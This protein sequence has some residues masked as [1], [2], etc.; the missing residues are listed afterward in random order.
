MLSVRSHER[1]DVRTKGLGSWHP[2]TRETTRVPGAVVRMHD[3]V[4]VNLEV[5][6][7]PELLSPQERPAVE[8]WG[9]SWYE[10]LGGGCGQVVA[11]LE[12]VP[13]AA[14][15]D[16][17]SLHTPCPCSFP[18]PAICGLRPLK[19]EPQV[20]L[21][22]SSSSSRSQVGDRHHSSCPPP[23][24]LQHGEAAG[25]GQWLMCEWAPGGAGSTLME[26]R[27]QGARAC[28]EVPAPVWDSWQ[29]SRCWRVRG[30]CRAWADPRPGSALTPD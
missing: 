10:W 4:T 29:A 27:P 23:P 28:A 22:P 16:A 12:G 8:A 15:E 6:R 13:G 3:R 2:A 25:Q 1:P 7:H 19:P 9:S 17:P 24:D 11:W 5:R 30:P 14:L 26:K 21:P 20:N 18:H